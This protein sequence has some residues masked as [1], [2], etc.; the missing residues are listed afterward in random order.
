VKNN[1][2]FL[3]DLNQMEKINLFDN[4]VFGR[5][6]GSDILV[7]DEEVSGSHFKI[8]IIDYEVYVVD[9]DSSNKTFIND[10]ELIP[11]KKFKLNA[12]DIIRVGTQEF[13][14]SS[15]SVNKLNL[16][17]L[18]KTLQLAR[19]DQASDPSFK[20]DRIENDQIYEEDDSLPKVDILLPKQRVETGLK[21][22]RSA[23]RY[24]EE[25]DEV[26]LDICEKI[27]GLKKMRRRKIEVGAKMDQMIKVLAD[28]KYKSEKEFE[29]ELR[30]HRGTV[31]GF[32]LKI[33]KEEKEIERANEVIRK[34]EQE[35]AQAK[36][37]IS[38]LNGESKKSLD[39]FDSVND[40]YDMYKNKG[41]FENEFETLKETIK[42]FELLDLESKL[43]EVSKEV[44]LKTAQFKD[45]QSQYGAK[46]NSDI[47]KK[48]ASE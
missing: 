48:A 31:E 35:I 1:D 36:F 24:L 42:K 7:E 40:E 32:K 20:I 12:K 11:G 46:I 41:V 29:N 44:K 6:E 30:I 19:F 21:A 23:K 2:F 9:L 37:N 8:H 47:K 33:K 18:S 43:D 17:E 25:L 13:S 5:D 28:S 22:L 34:A 15:S 16:P 4:I 3:F 26:N 10:I 27:E 45:M 14:Y 39:K 38:S